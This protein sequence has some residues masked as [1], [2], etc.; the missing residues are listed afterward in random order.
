MTRGYIKEVPGNAQVAGAHMR[1]RFVKAGNNAD[2]ESVPPNQVIFD[3]D[4]IGTLSLL[5]SGQYRHFRVADDPPPA[6]TIASWPAL[7]YVPLCTF[8]FR[9]YLG[10][11]WVP[12]YVPGVSS[13]PELFNIAV[14]RAGISVRVAVS[15]PQYVDIAWQAYRLVVV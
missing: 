6:V 8:Q 15:S 12:Y 9:P 13:Y 11:V 5:Y 4:D 1:M 2:S 10:S 14:S 7:S 3:S